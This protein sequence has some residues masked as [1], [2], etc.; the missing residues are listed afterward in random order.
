[1]ANNPLTSLLRYTLWG[2]TLGFA[3][4]AGLRGW[5]AG[6]AGGSSSF[7]WSGTF[8]GVLLPATV[9][10]AALGY[11]EHARHTGSGR[12]RRWTALTPLVFVVLPALVQDDFIA[13][14]KTGL[15]TGAIGTALIGIIGGYALAGRGPRWARAL[16]RTAAAAMVGATVVGALV[17]SAEPRLRPT[18][19]EGA[20]ILVTI[21]VLWGLLAVA[22][23]IPHLDAQCEA[24][25]APRSD[26]V[27][28][29]FGR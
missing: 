18:T 29:V 9:V 11:A 7:T 6:V 2:A 14:L 1:M 22:C 26:G 16:S 17:S 10:G 13:Q 25:H 4:G 3:W 27:N 15:G 12:R 24:Q 19:P 23:T 21:L 20:Y 5:M 28:A 8:I